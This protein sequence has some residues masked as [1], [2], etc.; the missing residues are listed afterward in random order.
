MKLS[1]GTH[2]HGTE[3]RFEIYTL[4]CNE[5]KLGMNNDDE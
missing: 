3:K 2:A 5:D 4:K 1:C